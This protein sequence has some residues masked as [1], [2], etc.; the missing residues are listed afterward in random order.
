MNSYNVDLFN[1]KK[2]KIRISSEDKNNS[3]DSNS[4]FTIN[5]NP[6]GSII[7]N[8]CGYVVKFI[9]CANVFNNVETYNYT[10][11]LTST[12]GATTYSITLPTGYYLLSDFITQLQT[13][14]NAIIPDTVAIVSVG[15]YPNDKIQFT[16][17]GDSYT[18]ESTSTILNQLG[19]N[20]SLLCSD[21]IA[22]I[23]QNIPNLTGESE[24]YVHS[25]TLNNAGIIEPDGQ[26]SVVDILALDKPF[27]SVCYSNF[28]D[29]ELHKRRYVPYESKRSFRNIQITLRNRQGNIIRSS[30]CCLL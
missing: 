27:G 6:D 21:G 12:V 5:L 25:K 26:F 23:A 29:A 22:T 24:L 28:N 18:I 19:V 17:T 3:N 20:T 1:L 4:R 16:F 10:L 2:K 13:S 7:D 30:L 8:I 11:V 15:T 14:I 9:S